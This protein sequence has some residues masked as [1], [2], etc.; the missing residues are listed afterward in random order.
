MLEGVYQFIL[1]GDIDIGDD[2]SNETADLEVSMAHV[3]LADGDPSHRWC[4]EC[5]I[6]GEGIDRCALKSVDAALADGATR[7]A[8][9]PGTRIVRNLA[10]TST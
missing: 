2:C 5:L 6:L 8:R 9:S 4:S 3:E 7:D 10:T 1:D